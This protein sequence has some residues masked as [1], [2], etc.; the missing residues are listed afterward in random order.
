MWFELL[1]TLPQ[2]PLLPRLQ[3]LLL[4]HIRILRLLLGRLLAQLQPD[5]FIFR[6]R[7]QRSGDFPVPLGQNHNSL[8]G[9]GRQDESFTRDL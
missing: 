8:I 3:L 7:L 2:R 1:H 5:D 6:L 4:H 9:P